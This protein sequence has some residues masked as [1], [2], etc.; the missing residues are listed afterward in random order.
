MISMPIYTIL[1]P[2]VFLIVIGLIMSGKFSR[3]IVGL[4]GSLIIIIMMLIESVPMAT[5]IGFLIGTPSNNF[6]NFFSILLIFGMLIIISICHKSGVFSIIAFK[7]VQKTG[8]NRF[9]LFSVL[10]LLSFLFSAILNNILTILL[11]IP[12]TITI[13]KI[14][15]INPIPYIISEALIVNL[16]GILFLISSIPNILISE[17]IGWTF[18]QFF[19]EVGF[20]SFILLFIT[21]IFL[22]GCNKTKLEIPDK[23]LIKVLKEYD[24]WIFVKDKKSFYI[25]FLMLII[26][27]ICFIIVPIIIP[28]NIG[29]IAISSGVILIII[30][31]QDIKSLIK[32]LD[33]ELILYLLSIF[34]ITDALEFTG[35]LNYISNFLYYLTQGNPLTTSLLILWGS[36]FLSSS[37]DNAPITKIMIPIVD[38][39]IS[40]SGIPESLSHGIFASLVYGA[41]IGDNL[42]PMGD[43]ILTFQILEDYN[44]KISVKQFFKIGFISTIVQ[45]IGISIYIVLKFNFLFF[46]FGMIILVGISLFFLIYFFKTEIFGIIKNIFVK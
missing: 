13:C 4:S 3:V 17:A 23:N 34:L 29:L 2:V 40:I 9:I 20:F 45:L 38:D 6:V 35:L 19:Y 30:T 22:L 43:N 16:G 18:D 37:I 5:I 15:N 14:L 25:T 27:I 42:T 26:T 44:M 11:L 31:K 7:I 12:L 10:N 8:G 32:I 21:L 36:A 1:I 24:P 33:F 28:I 39:L 46:I 41:N